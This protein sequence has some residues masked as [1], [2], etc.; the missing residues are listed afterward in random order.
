MASAGTGA[1]RVK[2]EMN[3]VGGAL[4]LDAV[5][6]E[7]TLNTVIA[8]C[9]RGGET[10]TLVGTIPAVSVNAGRI[11][12]MEAL[13]L[14]TAPGASLA[15]FNR[16]LDDIAER[17]VRYRPALTALAAMLACAAFCFLNHGGW[18]ECLG[19]AIGAG[20]GQFLRANL[21]RYRLNQ[22]GVTLMAGL[23][24]CLLYLGVTGLLMSLGV[25][26]PRHAAGYTSAVLFLIPGFPL[27]T[28]AL[29]L[30]RLDFSA[31]IARLTYAVLII[32]VASISAWLVAELVHLVPTRAA[33][34]DLPASVLLT[35]RLAASFCGVLG[36]ALMFNTPLGIALAAAS[37]GMLANTLRLYLVD[38]ALP[39]Q[40]AAPIATLL[41]GLL[42]AWV[43][44]RM[45]CPRIVLSVPP[46]LIMIPGAIA[47]QALVHANQGMPLEAIASAYQAMFIVAGIAIGLAIARMLTDRAWAFEGRLPGASA[48]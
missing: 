1:Y 45:R 16:R 42:A 40:V 18:V 27:I 13:A 7:V 48:G 30:A 36:F 10:Q 2:E 38:L 41:V 6:A 28:A 46:V 39:L 35:L 31:G 43:S 4:G 9:L 47:Y 14:S 12:E 37:I 34:L 20:S 8:T 21:A 22:L 29:D 32:T 23:L 15:E 25:P 11:L 19:V 24:A 3:R 5:H 33:P 26:S 44:P 17:P